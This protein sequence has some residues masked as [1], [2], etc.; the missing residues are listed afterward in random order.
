MDPVHL[1]NSI[2]NNEVK[3]TK[4]TGD[5]SILNNLVIIDQ[6][7]KEVN[8]IS[9]K[10]MD[11]FTL[12]LS[13]MEIRSHPID[14]SSSMQSFGQN[15]QIHSCCSK[16]ILHECV[17]CSHLSYK[18]PSCI[19]S[20]LICPICDKVCPRCPRTEGDSEEEEYDRYHEERDYNDF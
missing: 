13:R 14:L 20:C 10:R 12:S 15:L 5:I 17:H 9:S 6:I 19:H 16:R 1:T 11:D 3:I 4:S 8:K 7:L 18:C 2:C